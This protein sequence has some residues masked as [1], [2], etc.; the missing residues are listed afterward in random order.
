ML[1]MYQTFHT[2]SIGAGN[3]YGFSNPEMDQLIEAIRTEPDDA[4]R[5]VL[6]IKAQHLIHEELPEIYLYAPQQRMV[7]NRR[8]DFVLSANRPGYYEQYFKLIKE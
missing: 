1:E 6:Y 4:K 8:F 7:A 2:N 3:R 5:N